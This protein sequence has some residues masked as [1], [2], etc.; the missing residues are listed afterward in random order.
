MF[1]SMLDFGEL[2]ALGISANPLLDRVILGVLGVEDTK[3]VDIT[4]NQ[5]LFFSMAINLFYK[6]LGFG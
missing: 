2:I 5:T 4:A 1:L 6:I 3:L